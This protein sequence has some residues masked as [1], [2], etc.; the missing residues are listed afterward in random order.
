MASLKIS[1]LPTTTGTLP[2]D[3]VMVVQNSLNKQIKVQD[4][5]GNIPSTAGIGSLLK[6]NGTPEVI[7]TGALSIATSVSHI[8]LTGNNTLSL[9]VGSTGQIKILV[10]T[11]SSGSFSNT[12]NANI[13]HTSI[14]FSKIGDSATLMYTGGK[15]AMI[16]GT[17]IVI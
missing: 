5:F 17:A 7:S 6:F 13:H 16:G 1:E 3:L 2:D 9:G 14:T 11:T 15:W 4:L 10:A 12:I 8:N